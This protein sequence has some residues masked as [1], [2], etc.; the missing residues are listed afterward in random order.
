MNQNYTKLKTNI[1]FNTQSVANNEDKTKLNKIIE[2]KETEINTDLIVPFNENNQS[3]ENVPVDDSKST[4]LNN[5]QELGIKV[6]GFKEEDE[7]NKDLAEKSLILNDKDLIVGCINYML[8]FYTKY[9]RPYMWDTICSYEIP[10]LSKT[11]AF[12]LLI[13]NCFLP[14]FGTSLSMFYF[15]GKKT[16][17]DFLSYFIFLVIGLL[18]Y[19]LSFIIIGWLWSILVGVQ[20]VSKSFEA[21][22][23]SE[24]NVAIEVEENDPRV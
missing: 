11:Q 15:V 16:C 18:Q 2:S 22:E 6:I 20:L 5:S 17:K 19:V 8:F 10:K 24:A 7:N 13:I 3:F 21:S 12:I 1:E 4:K 23:A 14:G 9:T